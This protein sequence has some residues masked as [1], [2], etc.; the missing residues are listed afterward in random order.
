MVGLVFWF[1]SHQTGNIA[2]LPTLKGVGST[3][4]KG[5]S[6]IKLI[7][8]FDIKAFKTFYSRKHSELS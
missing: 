6:Y 7:L 3:Y 2:R 5:S 4:I 1:L 8:S